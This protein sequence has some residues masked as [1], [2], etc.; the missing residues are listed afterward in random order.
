MTDHPVTTY[1]PRMMYTRFLCVGFAITVG[2]V[3]CNEPKSPPSTD[4]SP[5]PTIAAK[6]AGMEAHHGF[7]DFYWDAREGAIWL[8][9]ADWDQE[10]LYVVS[11][12]AGVGSNDI[13]LDRS[14][15]SPVQVVKFTRS[16]KRVLLVAVNHDYRASS[17]EPAE[18]R[19]VEQAFAESVLGGFD[20]VAEQG[21]RVLVDATPYLLQDTFG[22][23]QRLKE[24]EQGEYT[25]EPGRSAVYLP[26]TRSFPDNTEL[27]VVLTFSGRPEGDE[28]RA[29][30][31]DPRA[32]TV[33]QRHSLIRAPDNGYRPRAFHPR[34]GYYAVT[35]HDY[36]APIGAPLVK[37]LIPRHRLRKKNPGAERSEPVE[38]I[39]YYLDRGAPEPIRSALLEGASWWNQAFEAA[40]YENALRVELMPEGMDP[41]DVRYNVIQW[42]HRRTRGWS[43]GWWLSDPR[44][45]EI[46]KGHVLLGSLRVRQ[47]HL[48]AQGL[49]APFETGEPAS[50]AVKA[51][52]A[53][54]LARLRQLAAHELG[55][56][57]G[58]T[59]NFAASVDDRASVMDY[60]HPIIELDEAGI[61]DST[62]AYAT[63]IGEWDKQAITY[64]YREFAPG[65][66]ES[67][68]L[69]DMLDRSPLHFMSDRDSRTT[70]AAHPQAHLWDNGVD[71]VAE[72]GRIMTLRDRAM[73]N[74][75]EQ[76]IP[77]Q[78]PM[79][80]LEEVLVP[81][82]FAHR[83]QLEAAARVLGGL[84]YDYTL[85]GDDRPGPTIVPAAAQLAALDAL[86][87]ALEPESLALPERILTLIPPRPM[88][89]WRSRETFPARTGPPLDP[90]AIAESAADLT[91]RLLLEPHRAA[92][93]VEYHARNPANPGL[94]QVIDR[95]ID[96]AWKRPAATPYSREI[97]RA[98]A[99][100]VMAHLM[101][102]ARDQ[103]TSGQVRAVAFSAL[104][105]LSRW[106]ERERAKPQND[107]AQRAHMRY[108]AAQLASFSRDPKA[109]TLP[110]A[111]ALPAGSPIGAPCAAPIAP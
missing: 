24:R 76:A 11:L 104:D 57:L 35:H 92:R 7:F 1:S 25:V 83:Y 77:Q 34:S 2:A 96:M 110:P 105:D 52:E 86:L 75:G 71:P 6:T 91:I 15:P 48:I 63:G 107:A 72:L 87:A 8:E 73:A 30:T 60:P 67:A 13:G 65:S 95:T 27:E 84:S 9:I 31:P 38:P 36:S 5:V 32:V 40:G 97:Q 94:D 23:A 12:P 101:A 80:T 103:S 85:R 50:P 79:A 4:P 33:R 54:A 108:H 62:R 56:T 90:V 49:L 66:D 70:G 10:F 111:P 102:L 61:S 20:V 21:D 64:G 29:V 100:R 43:Y 55:H 18:Q 106:L 51:M 69:R 37:R 22:V 53:I 17:A 109:I 19:S 44:T 41:M 16:G 93:L 74:F 14:L 59:H 58:L 98:M 88:G 47:D 81:I 26:S 45:G 89:Y 42:V 46:I 28:I 3:A 39:V 82:Y 99:R 78:T 68:V